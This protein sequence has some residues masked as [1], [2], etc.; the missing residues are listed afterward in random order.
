MMAATTLF[1]N[2][3]AGTL[4][5]VFAEGRRERIEAE[6]ACV[7]GVLRRE[8]LAAA[9]PLLTEVRYLFSTWG[10][11]CLTAEDFAALPKLA[12][13]FYAAGTVKGF[14]APLLERGIA[15]ASAWRANALPV[16]ETSLAWILLALKQSLQNARAIRAARAWACPGRAPITGSYG[17]TVG[18][19]SLGAI[20]RRVV[21]LLRPFDV[22]IIAHDPYAQAPEGV[23]LVPLAELFA[24]ADVVSLH[25]PW[26][27][28]TEGLI[29][30]TLLRTMKPHATLINTA[31]GAVLREAELCTVLAERPDLQAI[32]D[33]VW[34]EPPVAESPLYTLPNVLLTP[35][36]AG[37]GGNEVLRMVD[38]MIEDCARFRRGEPLQHRVT[39]DMLETMA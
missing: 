25:L 15:L 11:P 18:L 24:R 38:W 31:R 22:R 34:P 20:G 32:L 14:A 23:E 2:Q 33:V 21:E 36:L 27:P 7:P 3:D 16:A 35:H 1:L 5:R 26:I 28:A 13:V 17:A 39:P 37:S 30:G 8:D 29:D 10:M 19:V 12:A 6:L 9:A 4:A